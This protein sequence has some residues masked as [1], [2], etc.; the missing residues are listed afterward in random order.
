MFYRLNYKN[1]ILSYVILP[2]AVPAADTRT[3]IRID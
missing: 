2:V 1:I 3:F